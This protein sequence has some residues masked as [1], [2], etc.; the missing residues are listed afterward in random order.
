MKKEKIFLTAQYFLNHKLDPEEVRRQVREFA[1][2]GYQGVFAHARPGLLTPYM[3][4]DWWNII[5]VIMEEC[6]KSG[7]TVV[8]FCES[9]GINPKTYYYHLKKLREKLCEQLPVQIGVLPGKT[10]SASAIT[11]RDTSGLTVE[12]SDGASAETITALIRALKC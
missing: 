5:D 10:L 2:K 9:N 6:R 4:S 7:M 11:V 1:E 8:R 12:I 3:S